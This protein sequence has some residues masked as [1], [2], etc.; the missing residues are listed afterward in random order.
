[1]GLGKFTIDV[2]DTALQVGI[3]EGKQLVK[4]Q[5]AEASAKA[6]AGLA[7][8]IASLSNDLKT[9]IRKPVNAA[10]TSEDIIKTLKQ[11]DNSGASVQDQEDYLFSIA[12]G[13]SK[14]FGT[15][16]ADTLSEFANVANFH[17]NYPGSMSLINKQPVNNILGKSQ[18]EYDEMFKKLQP[19]IDA[20]E[21]AKNQEI[22]L[23]QI[24]QLTKNNV[25][26]LDYFIKNIDALSTGDV[27]ATTRFLNI[28]ITKNIKNK[29]HTNKEKLR[30]KLT[31]EQEIRDIGVDSLYRKIQNPKISEKDIMTY[32]LQYKSLQGL[33]KKELGSLDSE[34]DF[35]LNNRADI[36]E[37]K[38]FSTEQI[39]QLQAMKK[40]IAEYI[41]NPTTN[42]TKPLSKS[43]TNSDAIKMSDKAFIKNAT[44]QYT[45]Q[46]HYSA[47]FKINGLV[48]PTEI[49]Y[50][51][52]KIN[53]NEIGEFLDSGLSNLPKQQE[54][55]YNLFK[56]PH[57]PPQIRDAFLP[58]SLKQKQGISTNFGEEITD[59]AEILEIS[60]HT[61]KI[62]NDDEILVNDKLI[63]LKLLQ[64]YNE[65]NPETIANDLLNKNLDQMPFMETNSAVKLF[66]NINGYDERDLDF[67]L[68][69]LN[70][71]G[72]SRSEFKI[73]LNKILT[74]HPS[75]F[76]YIINN[77]INLQIGFMKLKQL[78]KVYAPNTKSF[79][80][81]GD[82]IDRSP[83]IIN[84]ESLQRQYLEAVNDINNFV[85]KLVS[86]VK[87]IQSLDLPESW[88]V[89]T[90]DDY[91][92]TESAKIFNR[93]SP[94]SYKEQQLAQS[95][96]DDDSVKK[97]AIKA[98]YNQLMED[99][100]VNYGMR[101]VESTAEQD[102]IEKA[103][104]LHGGKVELQ[105]EYFITR[106]GKPSGTDKLF[107]K[108]PMTSGGVDYKNLEELDKFLF[109]NTKGHQWDLLSKINA[110]VDSPLSDTNAKYYYLDNLRDMIKAY[111]DELDA[112][113]VSDSNIYPLYAKIKNQLFKVDDTIKRN[114]EA[115]STEEFVKTNKKYFGD[116]T[117]N[118]TDSTRLDLLMQEGE[119]APKS[120][121]RRDA[122]GKRFILPANYYTLKI[123][124]YA[125]NIIDQ[126]LVGNRSY[127]DIMSEIKNLRIQGLSRGKTPRALSRQEV[128]QY[129]KEAAEKGYDEAKYLKYKSNNKTQ[130]DIENEQI[131]DEKQFD[132]SPTDK[133]GR[134]VLIYI[135]EFL[136]AA[137]RV[138]AKYNIPKNQS[139]L[140]LSVNSEGKMIHNYYNPVLWEDMINK[141][142][143]NTK[144]ILN[145][146]QNKES[147]RNNSIEKAQ[148]R[149]VFTDSD[150]LRQ[151]LNELKI[152]NNLG[153]AGAATFKAILNIFEK[154]RN[155]LQGNYDPAKMREFK[156][157]ATLVNNS[158]LFSS[159]GQFKLMKDLITDNMKLP[160]INLPNIIFTRLNLEKHL[161]K[162]SYDALHLKPKP[163]AAE[164]AA[165]RKQEQHWLD[166][167]T[168]K[169]S[170]KQLPD[171]NA[172]P[173]QKFRAQHFKSEV[174]EYD[175]NSL[176]DVRNSKDADWINDLPF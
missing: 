117:D 168:K 97:A 125:E 26:Q 95:Q 92:T 63:K 160:E 81:L 106:F 75:A 149:E 43:Y 115:L 90:T 62:M 59:I 147:T 72:G 103:F 2:L 4:Q 13:Y 10:A 91:A 96:K 78:A 101:N 151:Y 98:Y 142:E 137:E 162:E 87:Q 155:G 159:K 83:N 35:M 8:D 161:S 76:D 22:T 64:A 45:N 109:G 152:Q 164:E 18:Q 48:D 176:K 108:R 156:A 85:A 46:L 113:I 110:I 70:Q 135:E 146:I 34:L 107:I 66:R 33:S 104:K 94:S 12:A 127:S 82:I 27:A 112:Y 139:L 173:L 69:S 17:T 80:Q 166:E 171:A 55:L 102:L 32:F 61:A 29:I 136:N 100:V 36:A 7:G 15:K 114:I 99:N 163:S 71:I 175:R 138:K 51:L 50:P 65:L 11:M 37:F 88:F 86:K 118:V 60:P 131:L 130:K 170:P 24:N 31:K 93:I 132:L 144:K 153:E 30:T 120:I 158:Q 169:N 54:A 111:Q 53:S 1:M 39:Q 172:N 105:D 124:S 165:K 44:G 9:T 122:K 5:A 19:E 23:A 38:N 21:L 74:A 116:A 47:N 67:V 126:Y 14:V 58:N 128:A 148:L 68:Y 143:Q 16:M 89:K 134:K 150:I 56:N 42:L 49:N 119:Y 133:D 3:Q 73:A 6:G 41:K 40:D 157:I 140:N 154:V 145:Y 123:E 129:K 167:W 79:K 28:D 25:S 84:R 57:L 20:F 121:V 77:D 52:L 141:N 174:T